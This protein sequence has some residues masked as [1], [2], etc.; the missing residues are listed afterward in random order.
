MSDE[1]AV[2][3]LVRHIEPPGC[4]DLHL[5][6]RYAIDAR[7]DSLKAVSLNTTSACCTTGTGSVEQLLKSLR[8]DRALLGEHWAAA[9]SSPD[10]PD[11][12][13]VSRACGLTQPCPHA[14]ALARKYAVKAR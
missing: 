10:G 6:V 12:P 14:L 4:P 2:P 11:K 9:G 8:A 13:V 3:V 7:I 1:A 5:S